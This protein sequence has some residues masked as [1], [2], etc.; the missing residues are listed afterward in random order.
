M[1][2]DGRVLA[3]TRAD[4]KRIYPQES[5]AGQVVGYA[6]PLTE[7]EAATRPAA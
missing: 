7:A 2:A 5:L 1:A 6:T 3:Q 4:G